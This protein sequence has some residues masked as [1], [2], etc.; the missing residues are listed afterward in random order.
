MKISSVCVVLIPLRLD[1][2]FYMS[3]KDTTTTGIQEEIGYFTFFLEYNSN[4]F[5]FGKSIT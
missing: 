5:S 2:I 1:I 3:A 4:T